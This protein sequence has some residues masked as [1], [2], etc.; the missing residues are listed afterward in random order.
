MVCCDY[1]F[2]EV[3]VVLTLKTAAFINGAIYP[4]PVVHKNVS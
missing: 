1:V 2:S 4:V 3:E